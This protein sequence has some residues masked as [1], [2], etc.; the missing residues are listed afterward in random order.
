[1]SILKE[2]RTL[3]EDT[4]YLI[5]THTA[6]GAAVHRKYVKETGDDT[7]TLIASTASP[8]KFPRAVRN[9]LEGRALDDRSGE[10]EDERIAEQLS[11]MSGMP[12]PEPFLQL[13]R[14]HVRHRTVCEKDGMRAEVER[15]LGL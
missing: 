5:D 11:R 6:V 12:L 7:A 13:K 3:F 10:A 14:A 2:I 15:F 9:A 8:Y 1:M 4:G